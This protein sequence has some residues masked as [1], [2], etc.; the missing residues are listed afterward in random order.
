MFLNAMT[1]TNFPYCPVVMHYNPN[2]F[3]KW[4]H[5]TDVDEC[6][7]IALCLLISFHYLFLCVLIYV[8]IYLVYYDSTMMPPN[9]NFSAVYPQKIMTQCEAGYSASICIYGM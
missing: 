9:I 5:T 6:S 3:Q 7:V 8:N 1:I 4:Y 2:K